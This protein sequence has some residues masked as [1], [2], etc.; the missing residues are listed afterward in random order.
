MMPERHYPNPAATAAGCLAGP[1]SILAAGVVRSVETFGD[2][3]AAAREESKL[4]RYAH[5]LQRSRAHGDEM[6]AVARAALQQVVNLEVEVASLHRALAQRAEVI[7]D[8][9]TEIRRRT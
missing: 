3:L 8:L 5:A 4:Q 1:M 9:S 2:S 6:E 7:A